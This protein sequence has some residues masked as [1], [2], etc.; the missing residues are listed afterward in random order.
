MLTQIFIKKNVSNVFVFIIIILFAI[1]GLGLAYAGTKRD[2]V[3]ALLLPVLSNPK[4]T[5]E[6]VALAAISCGLIAV[7]SCDAEVSLLYSLK[8]L[9]CFKYH[10]FMNF[11]R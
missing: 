11:L 5:T 7:G 4:S 9:H 10:E 3:I 2:D 1:L 8:N 6:V